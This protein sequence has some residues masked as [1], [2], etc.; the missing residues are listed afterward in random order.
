LKQLAVSGRDLMEAGFP[1][2]PL[3]GEILPYLLELVLEEPERNQKEWLLQEAVRKY[4]DAAG[5][6]GAV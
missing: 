1:A 5:V 2:G 6:H 4:G 3:L